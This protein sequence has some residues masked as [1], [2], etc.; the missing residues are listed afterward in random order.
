MTTRRSLLLSIGG[1]GILGVS[2]CIGSADESD[3]CE[4]LETE[5][6]YRGWFDDTSNY[7]GTCDRRGEATVSVQTGTPANNAHWGYTPAAVAV[8]PGSTVRW[9]WTG[10]GGAHDVVAERGDFASGAPTDDKGTVFEHTFP[11][12]GLYKYYCS[13]HEAVGM[14]GAIFVAL[15]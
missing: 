3:P 7:D 15:E 12:P 10:M 2:G 5:P 11:D 13:P 6:N 14:K 9:E 8:S 1:C 4:K